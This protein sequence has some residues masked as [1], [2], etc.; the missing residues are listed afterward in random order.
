MSCW[1]VCGRYTYTPSYSSHVTWQ[2]NIC[3]YL[4]ITGHVGW[5]EVCHILLL[6]ASHL[7][8]WSPG[9]TLCNSFSGGPFLSFI[10]SFS[11]VM[12]PPCRDRYIPSFVC[13][14]C[15]YSRPPERVMYCRPDEIK[16]RH[17][18]SEEGAGTFFTKWYSLRT[19]LWMFRFHWTD[20]CPGWARLLTGPFAF[21]ASESRA[22]RGQCDT[23]WHTTIHSC[24]LLWKSQGSF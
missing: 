9:N 23:V 4:P 3:K 20:S 7:V 17:F 16:C 24:L 14:Q 6:H 10:A 11:A 21:V 1:C 12:K 2:T 19:C 15:P 8:E 22:L 13:Q 5:H 18:K